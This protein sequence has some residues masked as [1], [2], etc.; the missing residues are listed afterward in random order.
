[1]TERP[2]I[3]LP[4]LTGLQGTAVFVVGLVL[5]LA[6][7]GLAFYRHGIQNDPIARNDL[8]LHGAWLVGG[9]LMMIPNR[10]LKAAEWVAGKL[11]FVKKG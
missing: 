3:E 1:M 4:R 9:C 5:V 11:P 10:L 6:D 7:I 2:S 8:I